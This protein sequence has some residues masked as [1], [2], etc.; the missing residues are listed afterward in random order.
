MEVVTDPEPNAE[1]PSPWRCYQACLTDPPDCSHLLIVQDDVTLCRNF[2]S[3]VKR[4]AVANP[5][6]VVALFVGKEAVY[7]TGRDI[8]Q[9]A[10]RGERYIPLRQ[11]DPL[12]VVA[13]LWPIAKAQHFLDWSIKHPMLNRGRPNRSDDARGA[14]WKNR[15]KQHILVTVPNLVQHPD[16]VPSLIR[17]RAGGRV[18]ALYIGGGDP[19]EIDWSQE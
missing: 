3:A 11:N 19:L 12:P 7:R 9:A 16:V 10:N 17:I 18:A 6:T 15:T 2:G 5:D 14:S 1:L 13:T 4:I 8:L